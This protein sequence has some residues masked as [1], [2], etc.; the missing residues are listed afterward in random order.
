MTLFY[1]S[2][3]KNYPIAEYD[4]GEHRAVFEIVTDRKTRHI[5]FNI[6]DKKKMGYLPFD[7]V[8]TARV[9]AKVE[10]SIGY[11]F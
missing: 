9:K 4:E 6:K 3:S 8:K 2:P 10:Y 11:E 5:K 7:S 1:Q